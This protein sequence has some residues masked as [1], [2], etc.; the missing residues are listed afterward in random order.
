[1]KMADGVPTEAESMKVSIVIP[2]FNE[3]NTA[4]TLLNRVCD[5]P[6]ADLEKE[7]VIVE[8]NFTDGTRKIVQ[9]FCR[10]KSSALVR[11]TGEK[12]LYI[13]VGSVSFGP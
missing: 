5:Q 4:L 12:T 7:L 13:A 10:G 8:S 6:L 3:A 11:L 1:M 2:I 9:D